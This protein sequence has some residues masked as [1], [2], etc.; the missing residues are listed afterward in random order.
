MRR[1]RLSI[2]LTCCAGVVVCGLILA[3]GPEPLEVSMPNAKPQVAIG[4]LAWIGLAMTQVEDSMIEP[5]LSAAVSGTIAALLVLVAAAWDG[6]AIRRLA[7]LLR[8]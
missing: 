4:A 6:I 7:G 1:S 2:L 5:P 3:T 8:R